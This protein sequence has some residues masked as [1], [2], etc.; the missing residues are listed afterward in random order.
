MSDTGPQDEELDIA[1]LLIDLKNRE[2]DDFC[3]RRL[4]FVIIEGL[5]NRFPAVTIPLIEESMKNL[6]DEH[7]SSNNADS[8]SYVL[9]ILSRYYLAQRVAKSQRIDLEPLLLELTRKSRTNLLFAKRFIIILRTWLEFAENKLNAEVKSLLEACLA[10]DNE[11][12]AFHSLECVQQ[13]MKGSVPAEVFSFALRV[14]PVINCKLVRLNHDE[15]FWRILNIFV[16]LLKVLMAEGGDSDAARQLL[17]SVD[18]RFVAHKS[19]SIRTTF[20]ET[21]NEFAGSLSNDQLSSFFEMLL[22]VFDKS[23]S[24]NTEITV[25]ELKLL[26]KLICSQS[27]NLENVQRLYAVFCEL[28]TEEN[29]GD[30]SVFEELLAQTELFVFLGIPFEQIPTAAKVQRLFDKQIFSC[31]DYLNFIKLQYLRIYQAC[32]TVS[33]QRN[34]FAFPRFAKP[35]ENSINV[36]FEKNNNKYIIDLKTMAVDFFNRVLLIDPAQF[37]DFLRRNFELNSLLKA[38]LSSTEYLCNN[39]SKFLNCAMFLFSFEYIPLDVLQNHFE[40]AMRELAASIACFLREKDKV[41]AG[42]CKFLPRKLLLEAHF[43]IKIDLNTLLKEKLAAL[44][45]ADTARATLSI[46]NPK[47]KSTIEKLISSK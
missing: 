22:V 35:F 41:V 28:V 33:L 26:S 10:S 2:I 21:M 24:K 42:T 45:A 29:L 38:L 32:L 9:C 18:L 7:F 40:L 23:A 14:V 37:W 30:K 36:L 13:I 15:L 12:L 20:F 11:S 47:T 3:E 27:E 31:N 25:L 17:A 16:S 4:G 1:C 6:V 44:L 5:V 39:R 43:Y 8:L 46:K 19:D 34:D